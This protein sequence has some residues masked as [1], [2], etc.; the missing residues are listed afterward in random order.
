MD[1]TLF[2]LAG[3]LRSVAHVLHYVPYIS[4]ITKDNEFTNSIIDVFSDYLYFRSDDIFSKLTNFTDYG[5]NREAV[6][7]KP[8]PAEFES[9]SDDQ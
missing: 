5:F 9:D 6:F 7:G 2:L 3:E 4:E 8:F 1:N